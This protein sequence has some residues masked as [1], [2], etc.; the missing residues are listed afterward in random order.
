MTGWSADYKLVVPVGQLPPQLGVYLREDWWS[1]TIIVGCPGRLIGFKLQE[2]GH[3]V[4]R[5]CTGE[6]PP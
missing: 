3:C 5:L 1:C 6:H 4:C 2:T